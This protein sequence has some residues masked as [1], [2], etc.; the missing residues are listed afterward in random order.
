MNYEELEAFSAMKN[1][2]SRTNYFEMLSNFIYKMPGLV[3]TLCVP[4]NK[5][6]QDAFLD[7]IEELQ[8][9]LIEIGSPALLFETERV[10]VIAK[11]G[12][13]ERLEEAI[14][15]LN[16]K[17]E[18]LCEKVRVAEMNRAQMDNTPRQVIEEEGIDQQN[19]YE[20]PIRVEALEKLSLLI[21]NFE[22]DGAYGILK[23]IRSFRYTDP[24]DLALFTIYNDF[25]KFDYD[26]ALS[27]TK[28]LI[29]MVEKNQNSQRV[30]AKKKILAVDDVPDVLNTVKLVLT[31]H[32]SVYGVTNYMSALKFLT[33]NHA[34]LILLDIEMPEMDGFALL[35]I[36]RKMELYKNTP[37]I[38]LTGNAS[39]ENIKKSLDTGGNDFI[40]KPVNVDILLEKIRKYID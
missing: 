18:G 39:V 11:S 17:I 34:D 24:I 27:T 10:E 28:E 19:K 15:V 33:T 21:E 13:K 9:G 5:E 4:T 36:I 8:K 2:G 26:D 31:S 32:Y 30:N 12:D 20:A 3:E 38:F 7:K 6:E 35:N 29:A 16:K 23:N 1:S 40:K 14:V 22:I 37:V 25:R